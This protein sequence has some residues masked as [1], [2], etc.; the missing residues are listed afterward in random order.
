MTCVASA[1]PSESFKGRQNW[2]HIK[3]AGDSM[4]SPITNQHYI[5]LLVYDSTWVKIFLNASS[6]RL[7]I[8]QLSLGEKPSKSSVQANMSWSAS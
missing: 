8:T 3:R 7:E 6:K 2:Q 5:C 1:I 4:T